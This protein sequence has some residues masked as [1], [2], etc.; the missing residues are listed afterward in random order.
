M[1][2]LLA[3]DPMD[4]LAAAMDASDN[5]GLNDE[6]LEVYTKIVSCDFD[7]LLLMGEAGAGKTYVLTQA[8]AQLHR[9]EKR[10]LLCA[11]THLARITLLNKMPEDAA[12]R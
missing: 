5:L 1:P 2:T 7:K 8:L 11:P 6:Q 10:V 4:L 3:P 9:M 12:L